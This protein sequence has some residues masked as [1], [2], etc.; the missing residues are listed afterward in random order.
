MYGNRILTA[1]AA[2]A[3]GFALWNCVIGERLCDTCAMAIYL[4]VH[5]FSDSDRYVVSVVL[6]GNPN[7]PVAEPGED[8][9]TFRI[10]G[11]T[12]DYALRI[13]RNGADTLP[14]LRAKV[15]E[16]GDDGCRVNKT[17]S[18]RVAIE[19]DSSGAFRPVILSSVA[20]PKC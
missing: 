6:E 20:K 19:R 2:L 13:V 12:G 7:P 16:T 5:P 10:Y 9:S 18:L 8:D 15:V 17:V 3:S 1:G 11:R 14:P 4:E